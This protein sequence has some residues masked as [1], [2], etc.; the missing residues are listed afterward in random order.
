MLRSEL[1]TP[2]PICGEVVGSDNF[3]CTVLGGQCRCRRLAC[4]V[5]LNV[6]YIAKGEVMMQTQEQL[7]TAQDYLDAADRGFENGNAVA[8]TERLWDAITH[9]LTAI[10]DAKGWSYDAGDLFPVVQKLADGDGQVGD[11]LE[12]IYAAAE[13]HPGLVRAEYFRFE[14]GDT[15][16]ARRLAREFIDTVLALAAQSDKAALCLGDD[17]LTHKELKTA[18]DYLDA[19]DREFENANALAATELLR[20]AMVHTLAT[21]ASE[22]GWAHDGSN[23]YPVVKKLAQHDE[24]QGNILLGEYLATYH[25]PDKVHYGNF[26]W[27]D[28]D[29]HR[30]LR[31]VREFISRAQKLARQAR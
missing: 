10:A 23:L 25:Y 20:E 15:H 19:A 18:Q 21:V 26:V 16:R 29:S 4:C 14:D 7:K 5:I 12:G 13:G 11:I 3:W 27:Q 22:K 30:M 9:T 1:L 17:M 8:G 2:T 6:A 28:G 31:V 24:L